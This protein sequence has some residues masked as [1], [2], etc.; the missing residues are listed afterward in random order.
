MMT[1]NPT[2]FRG[3][4]KRAGELKKLRFHVAFAIALIVWNC[5]LLK[6][7]LFAAATARS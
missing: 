6:L 3:T 1:R 2:A 7:K 4:A 5:P